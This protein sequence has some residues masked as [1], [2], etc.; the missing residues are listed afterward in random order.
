MGYTLTTLRFSVVMCE[1]RWIVKS[2]FC[3]L[4]TNRV[5]IYLK[6]F[7]MSSLMIS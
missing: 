5:I 1:S 3:P 6:K 7:H 2:T 4:L